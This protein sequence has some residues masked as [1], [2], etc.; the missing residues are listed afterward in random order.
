MVHCHAALG[1]DLFQI[2][3]GDRVADVKNT[4]N[5]ISLFGYCDP[6]NDIAMPTIPTRCFAG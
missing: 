6:L 2:A 4:A 3:V 1:H 5:R